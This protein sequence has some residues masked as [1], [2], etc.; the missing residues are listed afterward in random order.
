MSQKHSVI[1]VTGNQQKAFEIKRAVAQYGI[2]VSHR[3]FDIPEIQAQTL[4]EVITNKVEQAY[5]R[6][7]RPVVV[8]DTGI[9]FQGYRHFPGVYC[10]FVF[11]NLGFKG[12]LKLMYPGQKA[13][14]SSF[15]AFK[16]SAKE[17]P[18][19]FNGKCFGTL[20]TTIRGVVKQKMPYDTIFIPKGD[21][22]TFAEMGIE[23][24]QRYDHRSKAVK[25]FAQ[26]YVQHYL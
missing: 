22:R 5:A 11:M 6:I 7:K 10:R 23:D 18:V 21:T 15:L 14:F 16:G 12:L 3:S 19:L 13:Y 9:F 4:E 20:T 24:K 25:K 1:L 17:A 8:D 2:T 26:Y